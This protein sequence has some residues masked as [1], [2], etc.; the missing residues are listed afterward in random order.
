MARPILIGLPYDG[1]SSFLRGAAAAPPAIRAVLQSPAGNAWSERTGA[2]FGPDGLEDGGDL[3]LRDS[4]ATRQAIE[5]H[6]RLV[7]ASGRPPILLGGDHSV[8]CPILRAIGPLHPKL[9]VLHIDAHADLYD[10]FEGDRY[11][12]ACPFARVMEEELVDHLVQVGIRTMT[13]DQAEQVTRFGVEVI[14]M[15]AWADGARPSIA[16]PVYVSIDLDGLDPAFAPG[17]S[18]REPGGLSVRDVLT[19]LSAING[20]IVGADIVEYNPAQD[21]AGLTAH[22]AAKFVKELAGLML[23][24]PSASI[25]GLP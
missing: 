19:V 3:M 20:P 16:G 24:G 8:T 1:S 25:A 21:V 14:D 10:E 4:S 23:K 13:G 12:H 2:V 22:V 15:R 5:K 9:T 6:V 18:H 7:A 11:S 17:V